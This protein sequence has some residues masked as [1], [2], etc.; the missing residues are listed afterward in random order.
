MDAA[1]NITSYYVYDGIGLVAK[2]S[3]SNVYYYH[4]NGSGN[5]IAMTDPTGNMVNKYVYDE[6]GNLMNVQESVPN[7]FLFVGQY[8]VMDDDNGLL[9]MRARYL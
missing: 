7:P 3:G 9:Y 8:G 5:T 2:M 4:Y 1:Y 6:F